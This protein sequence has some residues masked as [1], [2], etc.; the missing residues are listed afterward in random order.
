[1]IFDTDLSQYLRF[2]SRYSGRTHDIWYRPKSIF[3]F[4]F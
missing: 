3:T 2:I 1:M 4:L